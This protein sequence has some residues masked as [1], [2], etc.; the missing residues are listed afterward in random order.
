MPRSSGRRARSLSSHGPWLITL[1]IFAISLAA[2]QPWGNYPLNDDWQYA[3]ASK[4]F[5]ETGTIQIDTPVAPALVGQL[6]LA[7]PI[8]RLFGMSHAFLRILTLCMAALCLFC[9]NRLLTLGGLKPRQ[10]LFAL[11]VLLFNPLF[12]YF[13]TTFMTELYGFVPAL[14]AAVIYFEQ[15]HRFG[16]AFED[17]R[18]FFYVAACWITVAL[19]SVFSFWTRQFAALV[20]PAIVV[21]WMLTVPRGHRLKERRLVAVSCLIFV[22]GVSG[23]FAWVRM[24]GNLSFAFSDPL[25]RM[26]QVDRLAWRV[27]TGAA[28]VYFAGFFLPMLVLAARRKWS[29]MGSYTAGALFLAYAF[30]TSSWFRS[31]APSDFVFDGWMHRVFPYLTN[32]IYRTGIGPITLDDVYH[33]AEPDRPQWNSHVWLFIEWT[34]LIGTLLWGF[35]SRRVWSLLKSSKSET[36]TREMAVFSLLWAA[37]SWIVTVQ[38][39]RLEIFD[40]YYCPALMSLSILVPL[41]LNTV[42]E[43][44]R[45]LWGW[46]HGL[47]ALCTLAMAWYS[48]AGL[49]DQFRWNDA[50]WNLANFAFSQGI[51][52]ANLAAG[53]E[54]NGWKNYDNWRQRNEGTACRGSCRSCKDD[55]FCTDDSYAIGMNNRV[56]YEVWKTEQ[57]KYWLA[58]GPPLRLLRRLEPA[59]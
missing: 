7:Y 11:L 32:V 46:E 23:Y 15:R 4:L 34:F 14:V 1:A 56:G 30:V 19:F 38:A 20:F 10:R 37:A 58:P 24:S 35:A 40:R 51:S 45:E 28:A 57:P 26:L 53:F 3:R 2:I 31:H 17:R 27:Q 16:Q 8:I 42:E 18:S 52:P 49:H 6:F 43:S 36:L 33:Q 41:L 13:S 22:A 55:W 21:T 44:T 5:A 59:S 54:V 48:I 25:E 50:R 9:M 29:D 12:L 47:A 39:Y